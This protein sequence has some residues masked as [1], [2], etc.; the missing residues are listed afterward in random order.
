MARGFDLGED[1]RFLHLEANVE[2]DADEDD[3]NQEGD[4]PAPIGEGFLGHGI[5]SDQNDDDGDE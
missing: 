1:R 5:L 2:R 3:G 4:T